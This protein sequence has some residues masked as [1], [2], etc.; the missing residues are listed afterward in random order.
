MVDMVDL[1][2]VGIDLDLI[3]KSS[4]DRIEQYIGGGHGAVCK[5]ERFAYAGFI[6]IPAKEFIAC[7]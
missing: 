4:Q 2:S 5:I 7:P 6:G 3:L 1:T